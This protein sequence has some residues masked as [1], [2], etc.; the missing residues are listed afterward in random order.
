MY[1]PVQER[2]N[3]S[4]TGDHISSKPTPSTHPNN[5]AKLDK[6]KSI[7]IFFLFK[8]PL[9][10]AMLQKKGRSLSQLLF[11]AD[12]NLYR[13]PSKIC[14]VHWMPLLCFNRAASCQIGLTFVLYFPACVQKKVCFLDYLY[15]T[16]RAMT[17]STT[18]SA[19]SSPK[20]RNPSTLLFSFCV[21][22]MCL[23]MMLYTA[24]R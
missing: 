21:L 14:P 20:V 23:G 15:W 17:I 11:H 12:F 13:I 9:N 2:D 24:C 1:L 8:K 18:D 16:P 6:I 22:K 5:S 4:L 3:L 19:G 10:S 7:S